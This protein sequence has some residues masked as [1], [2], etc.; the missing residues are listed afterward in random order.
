M[1]HLITMNNTLTA[2]SCRIRY[3]A[4]PTGD[5]RW[6]APSA[7]ATESNITI[8]ATVFGPTCPQ[9]LPA[10]FP[11]PGLGNEDCLFLNVYSPTTGTEKQLPVLVWIHGGG[12][13]AGNA[14]Q[15]MSEII[16]ANQNAFVAVAIQYRVCR[17]FDNYS[18]DSDTNCRIARCIRFS[19]FGRSGEE[20][21]FERW[22][23]RYGVCVEVDTKECWEIR[24]RCYTSH[25]HRRV[26]WRRWRG[27]PYYCKGRESWNVSIP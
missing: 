12:Y 11:T 27:A 18:H 21:G 3:A 15:D 20:R 8:D 9:A 2:L 25:N 5:M 4:P 13:G 16:N 14:G 26:C 7:P 24:W 10:P 23:P 22:Y 6:K 19:S 1:F 17:S